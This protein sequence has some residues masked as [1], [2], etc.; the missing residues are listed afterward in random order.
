[1]S[2]EMREQI[3]KVKNFGQFLN[4]NILQNNNIISFEL[5]KILKEKRFHKPTDL[6]YT[7]NGKI[8]NEFYANEYRKNKVPRADWNAYPENPNAKPWY[9][10]GFSAPTIDVVKKWVEDKTG[11]VVNT[12]EEIKKA[13]ENF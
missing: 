7:W 1:M 5:A 10:F 3:N 2:K 11:I 9:R 6:F 4:E 13:L 8:S 12:E